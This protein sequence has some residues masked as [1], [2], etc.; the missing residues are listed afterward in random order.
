MNISDLPWELI[1]VIY[2]HLGVD[3]TKHFRLA[4]RKLTNE[5]GS[6]TQALERE[7]TDIVD[8]RSRVQIRYRILNVTERM[9]ENHILE[10]N[11]MVIRTPRSMA[12]K[13]PKRVGS[14]MPSFLE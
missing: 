8:K 12:C 5:P 2:S 7:L 3:D 10:M 4:S 9:L 14:S 6:L 11:S 1:P 13:G